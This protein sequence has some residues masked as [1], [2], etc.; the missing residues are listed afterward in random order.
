VVFFKQK[1]ATGWDCPRAQI[2]VKCRDS[3]SETFS[4]QVLGRIVRHVEMRHYGTELLNYGYVFTDAQNLKIDRDVSKFFVGLPASLE[5]TLR[6][7]RFPFFREFHES[8]EARHSISRDAYAY[9]PEVL[10]GLPDDF[11]LKTHSS[12]QSIIDFQLKMGVL[13]EVDPRINAAKTSL[14]Q[15]PLEYLT[16]VTEQTAREVARPYAGGSRENVAYGVLV[17]IARQLLRIEPHETS[18]EHNETAMLAAIA[19][20]Q[21]VFATLAGRV[22]E[23]Y[24]ATFGQR[25]RRLNHAQ[26]WELPPMRSTSVRRIQ[27]VAKLGLKKFAYAPTFADFFEEKGPERDFAFWLDAHDPVRFWTKNGD[28]GQEHF[29]ISYEHEN[30]T[31]LF[32]PDFIGELACESDT[33]QPGTQ[34]TGEAAPRKWFVLDTKGASN[35]AGNPLNT[36]ASSET[37]AKAMALRAWSDRMRDNGVAVVAGIVVWDKKTNS[38]LFHSGKDYAGPGSLTAVDGWRSLKD[39]LSAGA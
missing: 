36:G 25:M 27:Q 11:S 9:V 6:G 31:R 28:N 23:R 2:L 26:E 10:R 21:H 17:E 32:F 33:A 4:L 24:T 39:V 18:L 37:A 1:L 12:L 7:Y 16:Y 15:P 35:D 19:A 3:A 14:T 34:G 13:D 20:N 22:L 29:S 38:W 8:M 30:Q 5:H